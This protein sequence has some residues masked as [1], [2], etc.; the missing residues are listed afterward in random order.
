[1]K[2]SIQIFFILLLTVY[3]KLFA[4]NPSVLIITAHPDDETGFA[5][6]IYKITHDLN[7]KADIIIITNGEAGYKYSSIAEDIYNI[8]LT[9]EA[10]GREYLPSIRKKEL[11]SGGAILGLRD[12]Y[13]LDQK[14]TY[15]T[16]DADSVLQH[17]WDTTFIKRRIHQVLYSKHYDFVFTLLPTNSTHGHHK[18]ATILALSALKDYSSPSKPI[19]LGCTLADSTA[20][21]PEPFVGLQKYPITA[22]YNEL[23]SAQFNRNQSFGY[24]NKL[25]YSI[26]ANLVIAEHKSQGAMQ[27][28]AGKGDIE[29]FWNYSINSQDSEL[30]IKQLFDRISSTPFKQ[31]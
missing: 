29:Y 2:S 25:N 23:P 26:I 30:N 13:F 11:M 28:A 7:G 17:V 20:I 14:D 9:K 5:A 24:N 4:Q 18:A 1:M 3:A 6:T 10:I 8:Q 15:Y 31:K 19:I 27:L 12:Y 22:V 16:L 21:K